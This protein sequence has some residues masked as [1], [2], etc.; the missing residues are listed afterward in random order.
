MT[1]PFFSLPP[2]SIKR[3]P[4][5]PNKQ[6]LY[7]YT[8][9]DLHI[10]D[11]LQSPEIEVLLM[12]QTLKDPEGRL[13]QWAIK[14]Q[15]FDYDIVHC[16]GA[17]HQNADC[18]SQLPTIALVSSIADELYYKLLVGQ[19]LWGKEPTKIQKALKK[20]SVDKKFKNGQLFKK[21]KDL[22][23][24]MLSPPYTWTQ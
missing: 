1:H 6:E 16:D 21:Y 9:I 17:V 24:P 13:A 7:T 14:I 12:A 10:L 22:W 23:F 2:P 18:L 20:L 3:P 4:G 5:V 15:A 11:Y 8:T 19:S